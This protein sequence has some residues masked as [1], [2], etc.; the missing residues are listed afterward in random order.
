MKSPSSP[1]CRSP[2]CYRSNPD[3]CAA[4]FQ[5]QLELEPNVGVAGFIGLAPVR[6]QQNLQ[7]KLPIGRAGYLTAGRMGRRARVVRRNS[8]GVIP[9]EREQRDLTG[10]HRGFLGQ[11]E[12]HRVLAI[13]ADRA[14]TCGLETQKALLTA[15]GSGSPWPRR[16][17]VPRPEL[18]RPH[19]YHRGSM[20]A[21]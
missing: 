17:G 8:C 6:V 1:N 14:G 11:D 20:C 21:S 2:G 19:G 16:A 15:S 18:R 5:D 7:R 4:R 13:H 9:N 12:R 3:S 10:V